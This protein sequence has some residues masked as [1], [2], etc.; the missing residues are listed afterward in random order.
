MLFDV[1]RL[2]SYLK[3]LHLDHNVLLNFLRD[4]NHLIFFS[5]FILLL[6]VIKNFVL[7]IINYYQARVFKNIQVNLSKNLFQSYLDLN[8]EKF[9]SYNSAKIIRNITSEV[10][11]LKSFISKFV[12][13]IKDVF[14]FSQN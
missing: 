11:H 1:E 4:E 13:L 9:I 12:E 14:L 5:V 6:F 3:H 7:F 10:T 8:Y 2:I